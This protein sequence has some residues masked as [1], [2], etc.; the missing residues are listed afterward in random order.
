MKFWIVTQ[1][2]EIILVYHTSRVGA[3]EVEAP[4]DFVNCGDTANKYRYVNGAI[5]EV[6]NYEP[7]KPMIV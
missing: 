3:I 4:D 1:G 2:E 7:P 5:I 6:E